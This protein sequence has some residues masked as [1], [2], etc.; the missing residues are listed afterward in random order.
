MAGVIIALYYVIMD[1]IYKVNEPISADQ[2]IE[3]LKS[4]TLGERRPIGNLDCMAGMISNSNLLV[5]AW[6]GDK[7]IGVSRSVTDYHFAC[8]L[9]DLAVDQDYQKKGIGKQLQKL[10]QAELGP[11]CKLILLAAPDAHSYYKHIGFTPH[12]RCWVIDSHQAIKD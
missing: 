12:N 5:T 2:F 9:S 11:E 3:V 1:I 6:D 4:S 7:L 10:T 8:Y